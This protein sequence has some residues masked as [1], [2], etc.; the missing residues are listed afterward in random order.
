M[1]SSKAQ[2]FRK[3]YSV[4]KLMCI[5]DVTFSTYFVPTLWHD[6][7]EVRTVVETSGSNTNIDLHMGTTYIP[8]TCDLPLMLI[9][10]SVDRGLFTEL[11]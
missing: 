9:M 7:K 8:S 6:G 1:Q 11:F 3:P 4:V 10:R 5:L 2:L